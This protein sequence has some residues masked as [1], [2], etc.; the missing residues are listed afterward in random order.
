M[1]ATDELLDVNAMVAPGSAVPEAFVTFPV[2]VT[3][4]A[5]TVI[6]ADVGAIVTAFGVV[7]AAIVTDVVSVSPFVVVAVKIPEPCPTACT[8][9]ELEPTVNT[10]GVSDVYATAAPET[11]APA[12][13]VTDDVTFTSEPPTV[14]PSVFGDI[15]IA[16]GVVSVT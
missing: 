15:T 13:L 16:A 7:S 5:P 12:A 9:P 4:A 8:T 3:S 10:E 6:E 11:T 2:K 1:V 14:R